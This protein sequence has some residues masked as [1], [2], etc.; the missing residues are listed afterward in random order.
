MYY[1]ESDSLVGRLSINEED[2][3]AVDEYLFKN[4]GAIVRLGRVVDF[5]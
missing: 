4:Q 1:Q 3:A 2:I 5:T